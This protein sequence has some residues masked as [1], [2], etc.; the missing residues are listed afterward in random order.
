MREGEYRKYVFLYFCMGIITILVSSLL[1]QK[2]VERKVAFSIAKFFVFGASLE[3]SI[4]NILK[5]IKTREAPNEKDI[6]SLISNIIKRVLRVHVVSILI[7]IIPGLITILVLMQQNILLETQNER[8][9]EQ[10]ILTESTRRN[11]VEAQLNELISQIQ[12][13]LN[14]NK[15]GTLSLLLTNRIISS[16]YTFRHYK[17]LNS[18]GSLNNKLLSP[19][20]A[21]LFIHLINSKIN[22]NIL[23]SIF[24]QGNFTYSDLSGLRLKNKVVNG[25]NLENSYL[26]TSDFENITFK[27]CNL[28]Y[29]TIDTSNFINCKLN[30]CSIAGTNFN[31]CRLVGTELNRVGTDKEF[32]LNY[33]NEEPFLFQIIDSTKYECIIKHDIDKSYVGAV[34]KSSLIEKCI[35]SKCSMLIGSNF[36]ETKIFN[37]EGE[38][39]IYN[40][41][42]D[43]SFIDYNFINGVS[44]NS[45]IS[46]CMVCGKSKDNIMN[47][48]KLDKNRYSIGKNSEQFVEFHP[49]YGAVDAFGNPLSNKFCIEIKLE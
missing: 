44:K 25:I 7:A 33:L 8:I 13:E 15:D 9:K 42:F 4:N 48:I 35:F 2:K 16:T 29:A 45:T 49:Y 17:Y 30:F 14:E 31:H 38:V 24:S 5:K 37:T 19:E 32:S 26:G 34:F 10:N 28:S 27:N 3:K 43:K 20:R 41:D 11:K 12:N 40:C 46:N 39:Y 6:S 47:S 23:D 21:D 36:I 1:T 22:S 18:Q